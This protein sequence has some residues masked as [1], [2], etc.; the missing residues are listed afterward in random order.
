LMIMFCVPSSILKE[1]LKKFKQRADVLFEKDNIV[2]NETAEVVEEKVISEPPY[3][4]RKKVRKELSAKINKSH[5]LSYEGSGKKFSVNVK[6]LRRLLSEKN[7][8][9]NVHENELRIAAKFR[10][11]SFLS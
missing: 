1:R 3:V 2:I 4:I 8:L 5:I 10:S 9:F 7:L 6:L 11:V